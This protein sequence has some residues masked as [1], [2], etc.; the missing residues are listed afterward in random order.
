MLWSCWLS[1]SC[2]F[3][4]P[5]FFHF[6]TPVMFQMLLLLSDITGE[7]ILQPNGF[8]FFSKLLFLVTLPLFDS[9]NHYSWDKYLVHI[10]VLMNSL[11]WL[12]ITT[13]FFFFCHWHSWK[14]YVGAKP[15]I[16]III[17]FF[18]F[19]RTLHFSV[20]FSIACVFSI[21]CFFLIYFLFLSQHLLAVCST[22]KMIKTTIKN[23]F[24]HY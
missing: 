19:S 9:F 2:L 1:S 5:N 15:L 24:L 12:I 20:E 3:G 8:L 10:N 7:I 17:I 21:A 23:N 22:G 11:N 6:V 4:N 16:P 13:E 18:C 14:L